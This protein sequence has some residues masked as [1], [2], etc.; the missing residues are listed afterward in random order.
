MS[1]TTEYTHCPR[2]GDNLTTVGYCRTKGCPVHQETMRNNLERRPNRTDAAIL[3]ARHAYNDATILK[4]IDGGGYTV[5]SDDIVIK[6]NRYA[7]GLF[8]TTILKAMK[9]RQDLRERNPE[10]VSM[11]KPCPSCGGEG[12]HTH[13]EGSQKHEE[14]YR[15]FYVTGGKVDDDAPP[16]S[17]PILQH[18][19]PCQGT[20]SVLKKQPSPAPDPVDAKL[21]ETMRE[22]V[23]GSPKLTLQEIFEAKE[24]LDRQTKMYVLA[25]KHLPDDCLGIMYLRPEDRDQLCPEY[26]ALIKKGTQ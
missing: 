15:L 25:S 8:E 24:M 1:G 22:H 21:K 5:G 18:C 6:M 26:G 10:L 4:V 20:G 16:K 2:C 19:T 17:E 9:E 13:F 7:W 12:C 11:D 3:Q 14:L 23:E